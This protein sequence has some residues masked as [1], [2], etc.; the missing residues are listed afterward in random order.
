M[1]E[2]NKGLKASSGAL[3]VI[4]ESEGLFLNAYKCPAGK[5]T[6]GWGHTSG[7]TEK[8]RISIDVAEKFLRMDLV[9]VERAILSLVKVPLT[10]N[11]FD[12]LCSFTF[13]TGAARL[14]SS[15][16]LEKLNAS[17][18]SGAA[19]EFDKWVL[20]GKKRLQGLIVRRA[21]ERRLFDGDILK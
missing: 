7:V 16:L 10:Q 1:N 18:Y 12:A 11:Q 20:V 17:D 21:A 4:K 5:L 2:Q 13:N 14:K 19:E 6:I 8:M 3:K 9:V 15:T